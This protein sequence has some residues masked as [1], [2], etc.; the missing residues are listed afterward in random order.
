MSRSW[1]VSRILP[2]V[3]SKFQ[4]W[5]LDFWSILSWYLYRMIDRNLFSFF[6]RWMT[7]F[8][9]LI[10]SKNFFPIYISDTFVKNPI[11]RV[12]WI[13]LWICGSSVLFH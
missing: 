12:W 6:Y 3:V 13:D 7:V 8:P 1:S 2:L 9:A 5:H 10:F 11:T 4:V